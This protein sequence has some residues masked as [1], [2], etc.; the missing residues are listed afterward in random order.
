[1]ISVTDRV[2]LP[3]SML[4]KIILKFRIT[5]QSLSHFVFPY[6]VHLKLVIIEH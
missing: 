2:H 1:V 4:L 6:E 3:G 5:Q